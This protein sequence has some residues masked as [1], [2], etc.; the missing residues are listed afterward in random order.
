MCGAATGP[1]VVGVAE[2]RWPADDGEPAW[3][4][5][6]RQLAREAGRD[7]VRDERLQ[8]AAR[9]RA[10]RRSGVAPPEDTAG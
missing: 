2:T 8:T 5:A 1:S 3:I 6:A 10:A 7:A 4:V 9:L